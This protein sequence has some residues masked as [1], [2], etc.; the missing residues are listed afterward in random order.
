M[1]DAHSNVL[2]LGH[3]FSRHLRDWSFWNNCMNLNLDR[4]R[5]TVFWH[6]TWAVFGVLVPNFGT[7]AY[8]S[9]E[10]VR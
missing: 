3:S 1:A 7:W 8:I 9:C 4:S 6:G 2:V 10:C 5:V